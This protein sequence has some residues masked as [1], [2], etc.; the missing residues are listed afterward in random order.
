M[1]RMKMA[2]ALLMSVM[3]VF[4]NAS[5]GALTMGEGAYAEEL[6]VEPAPE[7]ELEAEPVLEMTPEQ[8]QPEVPVEPQQDVPTPPVQES[9]PNIEA[10]SDTQEETPADT[11]K[12]GPV[13][14]VR[15]MLSAPSYQVGQKLHITPIITGGRG[16]CTLSYWVYNQ[17]G[18]VAMQVTNTQETSIDFDMVLPGR[19]LVRVYATDNETGDVCDSEWITVTRIMPVQISQVTFTASSYQTGNFMYASVQASGG[20][21]AYTYSY[22]VYDSYG[23]IVWQKTNSTDASVSFALTKS[24]A[25]L[26]RVYV[27][28]SDTEAWADSEWITVT[29]PLQVPPVEVTQVLL[30]AERYQE[31]ETLRV[32]PF[33]TG[34]QGP[35]LYSY[36]LY[37]ENGV[38]VDQKTGT[39]DAIADFYLGMPGRYM[40]RVYATDYQ[41]EDWND[42][43]WFEV[44][45]MLPVQVSQVSL[46]AFSYM[47]GN[48]LYVTPLVTGGTGPY[49]YNYYVYN[50]YGM[51]V[52]QKVNTWE[53]SVSFLMT[54][55]GRYIV[56]VYATDFNTEDWTDS[57]WFTV[58]SAPQSSQV[59][60]SQVSL[61]ASSYQ[62]GDSVYV[63]PQVSGGTGAYTYSYWVYNE[64]GMVVAQNTN[65]WSSIASFTMTR[66][67]I[68]LVRVYAT[69]FR[70]GSSAD[71]VWFSVR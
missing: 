2:M 13:Q 27:T 39:T 15:I 22:W 3:L 40:V 30:S 14:I 61:S 54:R 35:Y 64:Y 20:I 66:P 50:E 10:S 1:K 67:G 38:I 12:L 21:G 25:Y 49:Y 36:W 4:S 7:L 58:T 71:S 63:T 69:D 53:T 68:Y 5:F 11:E 51:L 56:R 28:D 55:A 62:V 33:V 70:T 41:T 37:N 45:A 6:P 59:Q 34:G 16:P 47:E 44:A 65:T 57:Q 42:S 24:G 29:S 43:S 26:M 31:G 48:R 17:Q 46:S 19:Y 23:Q 9:E 8:V 18:G 52:W 32:T 60:V